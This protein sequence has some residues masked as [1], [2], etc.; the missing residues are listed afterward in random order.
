MN[1]L[2]SHP[3]Y[4]PNDYL[5]NSRD[6]VIRYVSDWIANASESVLWIHGAAGLGKSTVAQDLVQLLQSVNRLAGGVFLTNLTTEPPKRVIQMISRQLGT[7]Y[8]EA[9]A[10]IANAARRL[11]GPHDRLEDYFTAYLFDPIRALGYPYQLVVVVDGLDEWRN[12]ESFLAEL[13]HIPSPS[14]LKV[15]LTSRFNYSIERAVDKMPAR[16]YPLPPASQTVI[17][18]YFHQHFLSGDIDWEGRKPDDVKIRRLAARADGLLIW[19]ATA[20]LLVTNKFDKRSPH[21][22]LDQI[23]SSEEKVVNQ[24]GG[25][26]GRQLARLYRS[27]ISTSFPSDIRG[28]L[29]KFLA[30][31]VVLQEALPIDDFARLSGIPRRT[32]EEVH[33]RL[34]A[35]QT[36]GDPTTN[37]VFPATQRFHASFIEFI[38]TESDDQTL[39]PAINT[40]EAHYELANRCLEIVFVQLLPSFR[41]KTCTYTELRGVEPYAVK[42]WPLHYSNGTP[43]QQLALPS[44]TVGIDLIS[45]EAMCHWATLFL[46]CIAARFRDGH[47]F[48]LDG[49]QKSVLPHEVA[50]IIGEEDVT[51][52]SYH[53]QCLEIATRLQPLDMGT[54]KALGFA[55]QRLHEQSQANRDLDEEI[56]AFRHGLE[57]APHPDR[58][59]SLSNIA[60]ALRTR[61]KQQGASN[62]LKEAID[63]HR[64]ALFLRPAPHSH[65]SWSLNNLALA[66]RTCFEQWGASND[67]DEAISLHREALLLC[68]AHH[69]DHP[70]SLD[71]LASSLQFRFEQRG[72]LNDLDEAISLHRESLLLPPARHPDRSSSLNNLALALK[73]SFEQ[74]GASNHLDE[75]ISLHR[76][77]LL[78]CPAHH[79]DHSMSLDNLASSLQVRF[80]Q[81]GAP[82]DLDE[83]IRL[84][85][86]AL[87]LRPAPHPHRSMSLYNLA[88]ALGTCFEQRSTSNELDEAIS[89]HREALL[90]RP[91]PHPNRSSSLNNLA[92]ALETRFEQRGTSNDLD[93]AISLHRLAL[94]LRP[95]PHP[96]RPSSLNNLA[97]ALETCFEQRGASN[98]LDEAISLHQEA[99][100]FCP[101][102][103]PHRSP[104][105]INLASALCTRFEQRGASND[106]DKAISLHREALLFLPAPHP[107]RS[108]SLNNL[109][110]TLQTRF[111]HQGTSNDLDEAISLLREAVFLRPPHHP[112]HSNLLRRLANALRIRFDEGK[113]LHDITEAISLYERLRACPYDDPNR[114]WALKQL[115]TALRERCALIGDHPDIAEGTDAEGQ[116][117][118]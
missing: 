87:L 89:L 113:V 62:D 64:E 29:R 91:A 53:V 85:R 98:D 41:G 50:I 106:L 115:P 34:T 77:A 11:N 70:M 44:G 79:P 6:D 93:E 56:T 108:M 30:A 76:E 27:A 61:F 58:A 101:A 102:S 13:A 118:M 4:R 10:D 28:I 7:M 116:S 33:Q 69:P 81:R 5:K 72:A 97:C 40:I 17:E 52:L 21:E 48:S 49:I 36:Q 55:Y 84:H 117:L 71:K 37:L 46:P 96:A 75:A 31:T 51:T 107:H 14:P 78:L 57:P 1:D 43:R 15:V 39:F 65:R 2:P 66:L 25:P 99:L 9:I 47:N 100:L 86:E 60:N 68:S 54:W 103:H 26:E 42:F 73:I 63:L 32:T 24:K 38:T 112:L 95:A 12:Y 82:N 92:C 88:T 109:A 111:E 20:Q 74:R 104:F 16:K 23:L 90:L 114:S 67:L 105:L 3:E 18:R 110:N 22:I 8:P 35:L 83:A 19:A 59:Q 80:Q 45:E 94:V